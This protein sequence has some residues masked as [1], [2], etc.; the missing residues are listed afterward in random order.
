MRRLTIG[1]FLAAILGALAI[2]GFLVSSQEDASATHIAGGIDI[3][4][5]GLDADPTG[6]TATSLGPIDTATGNVPLNTPYVIN[7]FVDGI[8][9]GPLSDGDNGGIFGV[10]YEIIYNPAFISIQAANATSVLHKSSGSP[11]P[12]DLFDSTPDTDGDFRVDTVDLDLDGEESGSGRVTEITIECEATTTGGTLLQV[13]DADTGGG[14]QMGV[15]GNAGNILYEPLAEFE[16]TIYCNENPPQ[17]ADVKAVS[18]TATSPANAPV[19]SPFNVSVSGSVHNNGPFGPANTDV[20]VFLNLPADCSVAGPNPVIIPQ[21]LAVSAATPV[22]PVNFS[23]TCT[24]PSF[25]NFTGTV[26][27][28]LPPG[29]F[30]DTNNGNDTTTS[31]TTTTAILASADIA[32][33][34]GS[35]TSGAPTQCLPMSPPAPGCATAPVHEVGVT[36][37]VTVN[38]TLVNNGP[39]APVPAADAVVYLGATQQPLN[40]AAVCTVTPT[41]TNPLPVLLPLGATNVS[42]TF[43]VNCSTNSF[44]N[45]TAPQQIV[46]AF[47]DQLAGTEPHITDPN[48]GNNQL[49][50]I[51][52][53]FWNKLPFNPNMTMTID[54]NDQPGEPLVLPDDDDCL[55]NAAPFPGGIYCEMLLNTSIPAGNAIGLGIISVPQPAF[56]IASG[57]TLLG[58]VPN[59]TSVGAFGFSVNLFSAGICA[60]TIAV[61]YP[62]VN[63]LDGAL[64]APTG[65]FDD[66]GDTLIDED[67]INGVNDDADADTD[68][69][70]AYVP[71]IPPE[72][73]NSNSPLD[74]ANPAVFP[75]GLLADPVVQSFIVG[76]APLWARYTALAPGVN[77]PVNILTFNTGS[78]YQSLT[79]TGNPVGPTLPLSNC[80]PFSTQTDYFGVASTGHTLRQCNVV[81]THIIGAQFV[82]GDTFEPALD[83]DTVSCSP[84]DTS[85]DLD[86]D[87]IIGDNNPVGD[88][89]HAG[90]PNTRTVTNTIQG[91]GDLT[92]SLTGPAVCDPTWTNLLDP[93]PSVIGGTQTS[94]ITYPGASGVVMSDYSVSCPVGGPYN[95]QIVSNLTP[96]PGEDTTNNQDE[97][98]VQVIVTCDVDGDGVCTP[99][100]NC[101]DVPNADQADTD[102]DGI[103]DACDPDDDNDG[104]PDATDDCDLIAEDVDGI[105]DADGCPDTDVGVT[106]E[107]EEDYDVDV[108]VSTAKSVEITVTNGNY[109]ANVRIVITAISDVGGCEVRLVPQPGDLYSEYY[110]DE[111]AGPPTPDTLT[112]QIEMTVP[113]AAGQTLVLN[114]TY[115]IHCFQPSAH[116]DAFELQVDA[117]PIAPVQEEELGDDPQVPPDSDSNNVHK[118][119]PDVT[120][121]NNADLQKVSNVVNSPAT[122]AAGTNFTVTATSTIRNN[123]PHSGD[124]TDTNTLVLPADCV[125]VAPGN[126]NPQSQSGTLASGAQTSWA[127]S[128]TVQCSNGSNHT[129]TANNT[130]TL[131]GPTHT[132]DPNSGNNTGSGSDTTAITATT[133]VSVTGVSVSAPATANAGAT[134]VVTVNGTVNLGLASSAAVVI[135][136]TGPADCTLTPTGGQNQNVAASGPVAATWDVSCTSSSNHVF[137]GSVAASAT[138]PL[139]VTESNPG[140]ESGNASATTGIIATADLKVTV[141]AAPNGSVATVGGSTGVVANVTTHNNGPDAASPT[142]TVTAF[143]S[144]ANPCTVSGSPQVGPAS[145]TVSVAS[146]QNHNFT[147]TLP[148]GLSCEYTV[149]ASLGA[150][151]PH[152]NDPNAANNSGLDTG[153]I[154]LDTDGDGV[155]DGGPPCDGPDNCPT[156]PNP[157]QED[158]DGDGVGDACDSTPDHDVLVKYIIL[159][160][161]AAVNLSDNNG[162]YMWVIAEVGNNSNHA[163]LVT[164]AMSIAEGVPA[165]CTRDIVMVLPGQ[166]QF[167]MAADEQKFIV[168]RVRY[169]CHAPAGIQVI[170][171]TVTVTITHDDIDGGGPHNGNDSNLANN[172]KTTTKQVIIQ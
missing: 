166:T 50:P 152:V 60:G 136:L 30:V 143:G 135:G 24:N 119:Y 161:P 55:T 148:A 108:S 97:N 130:L 146:V 49:A 121:W 103:G 117:L 127:A 51:T 12:F 168:W 31:A 164:V 165:G 36:T 34:G 131:T 1:T 112:S 54:D 158:T 106:V 45:Q 123:G 44:A 28:S 69:D 170:N 169:E 154:C 56:T 23:V 100:D 80:T 38:K 99:A 33:G 32:V 125:L 85:V 5:T 102:G 87:E 104:N 37:S 93:F 115:N 110:T 10:G 26:S 134:F 138:Y 73:P 48:P 118:N 149:D 86:K 67:P 40:V 142:K 96:G 153:V 29:P 113:M 144:G 89:I 133:D 4:A 163:E 65:G 72:G 8:P 20:R 75:T 25:H 90:I 156:V 167:V 116:T 77:I 63:L 3:T 159:V 58:G 62:A 141:V 2:T 61:P 172:T 101:P 155:D 16:P 114:Y 91:S 83:A 160:G 39:F 79:I 109:P 22:G 70:G 71:G 150:G 17:A 68:E 42:F 98:V 171:Q 122:V 11:V 111:V 105:D 57:H 84:S 88:L 140:N 94:V 78:A 66:D 35:T 9:V 145:G 27:V 14:N 52:Y 21:N 120:A 128:W 139:H 129:F 124:Y 46:L 15:L 64:P 74:L 132:K 137:N 7:G 41:S 92:L 6:N 81:G 162:R 147:I 19:N 76:G 95:I 107:K 18:A 126:T 157:G 47:A 13:F 43:D 59:G 53:A 151:D 82:R